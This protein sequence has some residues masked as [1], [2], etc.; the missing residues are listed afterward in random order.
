[1]SNVESPDEGEQMLKGLMNFYAQ[2]AQMPFPS[3]G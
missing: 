1:M 2:F 3:A